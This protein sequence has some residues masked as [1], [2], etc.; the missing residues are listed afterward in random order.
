LAA[1]LATAEMHHRR[2][3]ADH[4]Q[5]STA[6][7][8]DIARNEL[9]AYRNDDKA[10]ADAHLKHELAEQQALNHDKQ[11]ARDK[12]F[13]KLIADRTKE[14]DTQSNERN[15]STTDLLTQNKLL[16]TRVDELEAGRNQSPPSD[17]T[18]T[19]PTVAPTPPRFLRDK[20]VSPITRIAQQDQQLALVPTASSAIV[21]AGSRPRATINNDQPTVIPS[22]IYP[23]TEDELRNGGITTFPQ[24]KP[25][26]QY[27]YIG[28]EHGFTDGFTFNGQWYVSDGYIVHPHYVDDQYQPSTQQQQQHRQLTLTPTPTPPSVMGP[29]LPSA[30]WDTIV[31]S[32]PRE[33][34]AKGE[35]HLS[36]R[37]MNPG[38]TVSQPTHTSRL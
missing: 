15:K 28:V 12:S 38:L 18:Q 31:Y 2:E 16:S 17:S 14:F 29:L 35:E 25:F 34:R 30:G 32:Q 22:P 19:Q 23:P 1:N 36:V 11:E 10:K 6:R 7:A 8:R 5:A 27:Y 3:M 13:L 20:T 33:L 9:E 26:V 4:D 24:I 21:R 37:G